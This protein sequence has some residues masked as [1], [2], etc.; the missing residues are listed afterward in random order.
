MQ[1]LDGKQASQAIGAKIKEETAAMVAR[2]ERPPHLVA[3]LVGDDPASQTYVGNKEKKCHELGFDSTILRYSADTTE[4]ELLKE[5]DRI[6]HDPSIDGLI[7]QLP[8]PKHMN[9]D[10]ITTAIDPC[11]DVDGFHPMNLGRMLLGQESYFPATPQGIKLLIKHYNIE[12]RGKHLVM[13]GRSHI[14][15]TPL[16][17][18]MMLKR[19]PGNCT[20]TVCHSHTPNLAEHT[21]MA[22]ILVVAIGQP[23][24]IKA[25]MVKEG[26][27]VIDVGITR[28]DDPSSKRGWVLRGDV[29][30]DEVSKKSSYI[31]PVPGGVGPMTIIS[32][33]HNTLLARQRHGGMLPKLMGSKGCC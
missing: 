6:N 16:A 3:M 31:T 15:G 33:M 8:L 1:L 24:L 14:V 12:T 27:V 23:G 10:R 11:K 5:I 22:D 32:L 4:K 28:V 7:V 30:F 20:V 21:R 9:E 17:N 25:D 19:E 18:M 13:V 29:D 2:G 26:A